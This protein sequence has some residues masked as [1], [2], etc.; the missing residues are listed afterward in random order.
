MRLKQMKLKEGSFKFIA[1]PEKGGILNL[2]E[3]L[4]KFL[5][6]KCFYKIF[7]ITPK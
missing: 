3:W 6:E 7:V 5:R 4:Q 1:R 2:Q